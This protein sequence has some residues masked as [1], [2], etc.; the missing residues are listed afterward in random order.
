MNSVFS[1]LRSVLESYRAFDETHRDDLSTAV[2]RQTLD[3]LFVVDALHPDADLDVPVAYSTDVEEYLVDPGRFRITSFEITDRNRVYDIVLEAEDDDHG[4]A[5]RF[6]G[7]V[8]CTGARPV[9]VR[10][11]EITTRRSQ[12]C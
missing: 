5:Y 6:E 9:E 8:R 7:A 12:A 3:K 1:D 4:Y 11:A 2:V 10:H